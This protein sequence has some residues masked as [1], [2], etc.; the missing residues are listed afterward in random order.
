MFKDAIMLMQKMQQQQQQ[1]MLQMMNKLTEQD[2]IAPVN[3]RSEEVRVNNNGA[4]ANAVSER[5]GSPHRLSPVI[6]HS[7]WSAENIQ[8]GSA[9]KWL[10]T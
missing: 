8:G 6:E 9:T 2:R 5:A 3:Q 4:S 1:F 7:I 10:A